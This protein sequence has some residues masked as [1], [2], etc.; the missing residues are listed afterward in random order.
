MMKNRPLGFLK[1]HSWRAYFTSLVLLPISTAIFLVLAYFLLL[2]LVFYLPYLIGNIAFNTSD[3]FTAMFSLFITTDL[4][5]F[6]ALALMLLINYSF[7][8]SVYLKKKKNSDL[9]N[10]AIKTTE[11]FNRLQ[12]FC[13]AGLLIIHLIRQFLPAGV[14]PFNQSLLYIFTLFLLLC[15]VILKRRLLI[16]EAF[17]PS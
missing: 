17:N 12:A 14:F 5:T 7:L 3:F 1:T 4:Y 8:A 6:G 15:S 16:Q 9:Y 11:E 2:V 13:L 10:L